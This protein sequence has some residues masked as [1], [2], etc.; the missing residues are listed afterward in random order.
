MIFTEYFSANRETSDFLRI[1]RRNEQCLK[2]R[3]F[4]RQLAAKD[5]YGH[6]TQIRLSSFIS[7]TAEKID[8]QTRNIY[9]SYKMN[10]NFF[11]IDARKRE[12]N[13][14]LQ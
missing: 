8:R 13:K 1:L 5:I 6:K 14:K 12:A 2:Y 3:S 11:F 10:L 4:D 9:G 7:Q